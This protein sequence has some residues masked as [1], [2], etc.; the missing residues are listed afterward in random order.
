MEK[1]NFLS[2]KYPD[3]PGS[4][5]VERAVRKAKHDPERK[6]APHSRDERVQAYL[7]RLD[8]IVKDERGWELLKN[9]ITKEFVIDIDDEE[10]LTKIA[11]G[12][13]ESEKR[14]AIEQGRGHEVEQITRDKDLIE[15]YKDLVK[16]KRDIQER[17]LVSWLDYLQENDA[18]YPTWFRYFTVR[19]LEKMGTLDKEKG[20]YSKRTGYTVAPFPEL[21]S[22]A[23][24]FVYRMLTTGIGHQEFAGEDEKGKR[25]ELA[26]LIAKKDF[27]KLYTFAQIETAGNLNRE[28]LQGEWV[29]YEQGGDYHTLEN[30]LRGKGTG[31]CT[32]EGSAYS[33]LQGG[34]FYVYYTRGTSGTYSEPRVAI[35]MEGDRVSEVRGVNHRQELEPALIEVAQEKYHSFPGGDKFDKKSE[36]MKH[37]T[38]LVKKQEKG[39]PFTKADLTFLYELDTPIE[40]FGYDKDPRIEEI[41]SKRNRQEDIQTLCNCSPEYIANDFININEST[42]VY[43]ED[44]GSKITFFDF[45]EERNQKKLPQLI[46]LAKNIKESGSPARP[47]MLFGGGIVTIEISEEKLKDTKT[48]L[49]SY[50]EADNNSPHYIWDEWINAPYT[51]PKLPLEAIILSYNKDPNTRESSDKIVADMNKL[52]LRPATLEEM[53]ALGITK[54]E[55]NKRSGTYLVG[56]TKYSLGGSSH[57][58]ILSW[59]GDK[60]GLDGGRWGSG[61]DGWGRFVCVRK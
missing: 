61:W 26:K 1:P 59:R 18:Q 30:A 44:T 56:L 13:Y 55:F 11:H 20:E 35:R 37:V 4:K 39:E 49:Q 21:N 40:G 42:Q 32:A 45:R 36:D 12:L 31:W 47:D 15:K 33:H 43:Y 7:N 60:R 28:S 8:G 27:I 5:P 46:E 2:E 48:A 54:P 24:G 57:V 34:D 23:L 19:N 38:E 10:T 6:F 50:K 29:K 16:E 52:N 25:E 58:P 9:K 51:K 53:I 14:I 22:E 17:T 41:K 3:L